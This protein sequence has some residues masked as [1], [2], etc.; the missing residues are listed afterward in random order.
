MDF[1]KVTINFDTSEVIFPIII[2]C[3]IGICALIGFIKNFKKL[4]AIN[5]ISFIVIKLQNLKQVDF[6]RLLSTIILLIIYFLSMDYLK[7]FWPNTG[8]SFLVSS[9]VFI[10]CLSL[11]YLHQKDKKHLLII[12]LNAVLV[13]LVAWFVLNQLMDI[14]LP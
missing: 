9:I 7:D 6:F 14:T 11:I 1:L 2:T 13:P 12:S 8:I 4:Q 5:Y 3:L 10:F